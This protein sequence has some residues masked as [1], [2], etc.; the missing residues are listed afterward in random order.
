MALKTIDLSRIPV[1]KTAEGTVKA[2]FYGNGE[3]LEYD[4]HAL[5]DASRLCIGVLYA[6]E[7]DALKILKLYKIL[8]AGGLDAC[9]GDQGLAEYLLLNRYDEARKVGDA[10]YELTEKFYAAKE[11]EAREAEK[12]S[13]TGEKAKA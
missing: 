13:A 1:K 3:E 4:I 10:I 12:N 6:E 9:K 8:L 5:D 7:K 11:E 2:D